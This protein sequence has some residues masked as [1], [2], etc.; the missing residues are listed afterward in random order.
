MKRIFFVLVAIACICVCRAGNGNKTIVWDYPVAAS[1]PLIADP[2]QTELAVYRVEFADDET[3]VYMHITYR[4]HD[5]VKFAKGTCLLAEG[6]KYPV[7]ST[8]GL[9][10]DK[11]HYLPSSGKEDLTFHFAPLPKTV[12]TFDFMEGESESSFK[13]L[14]IENINTRMKRLFPS[15]WRNDETGEWEIGFYDDVVIYDKHCW[16]YKQKRHKGD[17]YSFVLTDGKS[18]IAV[19]V[20]KPKQDKRTISIDGK[21]AEY[22]LITKIT[23]PDY[24]TKDEQTWLKDTHYQA[25]TAVVTGWLRNMPEEL[26]KRSG[27]YGVL[28]YDLFNSS[29][30]VNAY[31]QLDSLGRFEIRVPLTNTTEVYIDWKHTFIN[32]VLEPGEKYYLLFDYKDGHTLFM[33]SNCRLQNELLAHP[34]PWLDSGYEGKYRNEV[35]A[36]EMMQ[37]LGARYEEVKETLK[38]QIEKTPNISRRYQEY[39]T[40][41]LLCSYAGAVLQSAYSVKDSSFPQEYVDRIAKLWQEIPQPYT[42]YRDYSTLTKDLFDQEAKLKY[43]TP[44]GETYGYIYAKY[45]PEL[46]RKHKRLGN[47]TITDS[48]IAVVAQWA[49]ATENTVIRKFQTTDAEEQEKIDAAFSASTL[50]KRATTILEREDIA[51]MLRAEEP[52]IN[53]YY[54]LEIADSIGCNQQQKDV[55]IAKSILQLLERSYLPL[56]DYGID[57]VKQCISSDVLKEKVLA[58]NRKY[59]ALQDKTA[60]ASIKTAPQDITDGEMLL[61][62]ILEPYRGKLVLLDVWGTW[63]VPCKEALTHSKEEFE[64]LAPYDVVYLYLANNSPEDAWKNAIKQNNLVGNNVVHYNLPG[65]QQS[66]IENYLNVHSFPSYRLFDQKGNLVDVKV[67]ARQLDNLEKV[68][69]SLHN[70]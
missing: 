12:Q 16:Q 44:M 66:A 23:L 49:E 53:T 58:E 39:A 50:V 27:E 37:I 29:K 34:I 8:D 64:R 24:P 31:C 17:R 32:T 67:D 3:R 68:C 51:R 7:K 43:S 54:A 28:Y 2:F 20:D 33:G 56:N 65:A 4:P 41:Y 11:E 9:E 21:K 69:S 47:I 19:N 40:R 46:L 55:V 18:D 38:E 63:C 70:N 15:L 22:S 48:E 30:E 1:H 52:L 60:A 26:W 57:L 5:W 10:L 59:I 35:T 62:N 36:R 14:G 6:K 25:D 42:Q 45:Y 61:R 13:V